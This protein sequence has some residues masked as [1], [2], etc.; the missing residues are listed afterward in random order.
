MI[1]LA[2]ACSFPTLSIFGGNFLTATFFPIYA[3]A[4]SLALLFGRLLT[5]FG[6]GTEIF[7]R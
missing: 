5:P 2:V 1:D 3:V 4:K 6:H 7:A